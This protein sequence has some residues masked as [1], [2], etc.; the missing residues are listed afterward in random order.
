MF[1]TAAALAVAS[2][3][4]LVALRVALG[5]FGGA[6]GLFFSLAWLLLKLLCVGGAVY[7][8]LSIVSPATARRVR[9]A[10]GID[11]APHAT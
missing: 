7:F 5:I 9:E 2:M 6:I 1:R 3:V 10:L 8:A 11:E 4:A